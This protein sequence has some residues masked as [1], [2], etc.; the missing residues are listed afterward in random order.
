MSFPAE[1]S[2]VETQQETTVG[3]ESEATANESINDEVVK[4]QTDSPK[5]GLEAVKAA[6]SEQA[7]GEQSESQSDSTI[8]AGNEGDATAK[9]GDKQQSSEIAEPANLSPKARENWKRLEADRNQWVAKAQQFEQR[10]MAYD[11][12]TGMV[13]RSGLDAQEI[14]SA[15]SMAALVKSNPAA[16]LKELTGVVDSLRR[17]VGEVLPPDIQAMV[18]DGSMTETAAKQFARSRFDADHSRLTANRIAQQ[19]QQREQQQQASEQQRQHRQ[20]IDQTGT[21]LTTWENQWKATD[22]D[23]PMKQSL[24]RARVVE[25]VQERGKPMTVEAAVKL[26]NDARDDINSQLKTVLQRNR[27]AV[28]TVTG[29]EANGVVTARPKSPLEAVRAAL[30]E[31]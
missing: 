22:P 8:R 14:D 24:V 1:T 23:F 13:Q 20:L 5:S 11:Q 27:P 3:L 6:L 18:D 29:G 17:I 26:A 15:F 19:Q 12:I 7:E 16:A 28:R 31:G 9:E 21:A 2:A 4:E 25:L 30:G 10:A